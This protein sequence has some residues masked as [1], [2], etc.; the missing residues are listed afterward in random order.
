MGTHPERKSLSK[1]HTRRQFLTFSAGLGFMLLTPGCKQSYLDQRQTSSSPPVPQ[2]RSNHLAREDSHSET[3]RSDL[4][5]IRNDSYKLMEW[6][7]RIGARM[8]RIASDR[9]R[10]NTDPLVKKALE[11]ASRL[12]LDILYA[13]NP[14]MLLP[15]R[16]IRQQIADFMRFVPVYAVGLS[17]EADNPHID[18]WQ[19]KDL[20]TLAVFTLLASD[21]ISLAN[22]HTRVG[23]EAFVN[24]EHLN[25]FLEHLKSPDFTLFPD[26]IYLSR[27]ER[28][29]LES[30]KFNPS[31]YFY[32]VHAYHSVDDVIW[33]MSVS[34][35]IL[36]KIGLPKAKVWLTEVGTSL[37]DKG[38]VPEMMNAFFRY[39]TLTPEIA[40]IHELG[41]FEEYGYIDPY[42]EIPDPL[43][44]PK[45]VQWSQRHHKIASFSW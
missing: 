28:V 27:E 34:E 10:F 17:N 5:G 36:G 42:T 26:Y 32:A 15:S 40:C 30:I 35:R 43:N 38:V 45:I 19:N 18:F 13:Y 37:E 6:V 33:R 11:E 4:L 20:R 7:P 14:Q 1:L 25:E 41:R 31:R 2:G 3:K 23:I 21:Q 9:D 24:P 22:P 44:F 8:V 29:H 12:K 16:L 39:K